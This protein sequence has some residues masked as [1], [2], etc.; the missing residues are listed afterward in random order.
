MFSGSPVKTMRSPQGR[1]ARG[2][3]DTC[4]PDHMTG[5]SDLIF[6]EGE[7]GSRSGFEQLLTAT[8][9]WNG[10]VLRVQKYKKIGEAL[11]YLILDDAGNIWDSTAGFG[12]AIITGLSGGDFSCTSLF[13]RAYI[14]PSTG[15]VGETGETI[16]VY[17][18]A[19]TARAAA[20]SGVAAGGA[21]VGADQAVGTK[22]EK[23]DHLFAIACETDSG[24]ITTM[25]LTAT[26]GLLQHTSP[27]GEGLTLS[28]IPTGP[29]GTVKRHLVATMVLADDYN[30]NPAE[31]QWFFV[32]TSKFYNHLVDDGNNNANP[33]KLDD[34]VTT[35]MMVDF[36][37][38]DLLTLAD[39]LQYQKTSIP[40]GV[41]VT[42]FQ[43]R[44]VVIGQP[45]N[46]NIVL[47]SASGEP[48]SVSDLNGFI[49]VDPGDMGGGCKNAME[50]RGLLYIMKT[51]RTYVTSDN[52]GSPAT[53]AIELI[54]ANLGCESLGTA[55]LLDIRGV[56]QDLFFVANRN[57]LYAFVGSYSEERNIAWKIKDLWET[58]NP[59][60]FHMVQVQ[61]DPIAKVIYIAAPMQANTE[62]SRILVCDYKQGIEPKVVRWSDWTPPSLPTSIWTETVYATELGRFLYGSSAG[63]VNVYTEA[64]HRDLA[65]AHLINSFARFGQVTFND[66]GAV[67]HYNAVRFRARGY[68][69]LDLTLYGL[70]DV[71]TQTPA[72]LTLATAAGK[73]LALYINLTSEEMSVRV[74][75][76]SMYAGNPSWF[77][78][79]HM[80][81]A[82]KP[83][84]G[85]R[86][87]T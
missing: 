21:I 32:P 22:I 62:P 36:F 85:H 69:L 14:S 27:G 56:T 2:P 17:D 68:G 39:Y 67:N 26:T 24:F 73:E 64:S 70:E 72:S 47:V 5:E 55:E 16:Y 51:A 13:N 65:G 74:G 12:T 18:G 3:V 83:R 15:L 58:I 66:E 25:G 49:I 78:L 79:T 44:L 87:T 77:T 41:L 6:D 54:D 86:P 30:G 80:R 28:N 60:Y 20:G 71:P 45:T 8:G 31:Q 19:G 37:D 35:S 50:N 7:C 4:P 75:T 40:A 53:W 43:G 29:A 61:V 9:S 42:H 23:G 59:K 10:T 82:G 48:E 63:D 52:G 34:N 76:N 81:I 46:N 57:G 11:R 38:A 84:W 1:W 33:T